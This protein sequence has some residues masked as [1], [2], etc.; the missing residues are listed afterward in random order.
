M[1]STLHQ[2]RNRVS[3]SP[4]PWG[5][6]GLRSNPGEGVESPDRFSAPHPTPLPTGE[7]EQSAVVAAISS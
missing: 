2:K 6:V 3:Y 1:I 7:R 5:E 4:L